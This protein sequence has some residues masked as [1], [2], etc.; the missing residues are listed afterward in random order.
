MIW[1]LIFNI[2]SVYYVS[3]MLQMSYLIEQNSHS[4]ITG[5]SLVYDGLYSLLVVLGL[6][7]LHNITSKKIKMKKKILYTFSCHLGAII[8]ALAGEI[9]FLKKFSLTAGFWD[10]LPLKGKIVV[11]F[12]FSLILIL[13]C[14]QAIRAYKKNKLKQQLFPWIIISVIW[15][16]M[17]ILISNE[18]IPYHIHVHHALFAG[19]FSC[20]FDDFE[21]NMDI[22]LNAFFIGIVIEGIDFFGIGE[23]TL[24][25]T[26]HYNNIN[27]HGIFLTWIIVVVGLVL[28]ICSCKKYV[29]VRYSSL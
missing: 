15:L 18:N 23:L 27:I 21:T 28:S 29:S 25:M 2:L 14:V 26:S 7:Q 19:F 13:V 6:H 17:W 8:F 10:R 11:G 3:Q 9:S 12:F 24:F 22:V 4:I 20:W 1:F 16:I 5:F